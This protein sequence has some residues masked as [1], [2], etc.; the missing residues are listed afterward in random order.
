MI[1]ISGNNYSNEIVPMQKYLAFTTLGN[2]GLNSN[3][4]LQ[5]VTSQWV[6]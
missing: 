3:N 4:L 6:S 5:T 1:Y 2:M